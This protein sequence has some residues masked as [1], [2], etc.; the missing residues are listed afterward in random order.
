MVFGAVVVGLLLAA[1]AG[2]GACMMDIDDGGAEL[3]EIP[4]ADAGMPILPPEIEDH[5]VTGQD[6]LAGVLPGEIEDPPPL[7]D[8]PPEPEGEAEVNLDVE[9]PTQDIPDGP[10]VGTPTECGAVTCSATEFCCLH[11]GTCYPRTCDGCCGGAD[12]RPQPGSTEQP[13]PRPNE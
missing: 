9:M 7:P 5:P 10:G 8:A 2:Y 3:G 13:L 6:D 11:E 1:T 4:S 12:E